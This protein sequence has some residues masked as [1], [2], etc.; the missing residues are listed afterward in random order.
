MSSDNQPDRRGG[1][2]D[3]DRPD[4]RPVTEEPG[5]ADE[6]ADY[7][8]G[9]PS[10]AAIKSAGFGGVIRY[11]GLGGGAT[12]PYKRITAAEYQDHLHNG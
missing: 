3:P 8:T 7:A 2:H 1:I 5:A 11:V 4:C 6:V 10:A 9:R 12:R